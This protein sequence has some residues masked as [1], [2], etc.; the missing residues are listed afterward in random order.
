MCVPERTSEI[1]TKDEIWTRSILGPST[2]GIIRK[3]L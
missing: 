1:Y 3:S 2:I